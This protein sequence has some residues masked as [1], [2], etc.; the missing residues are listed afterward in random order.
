M[1]GRRARV[2]LLARSHER[3]GT[4]PVLP[5]GASRLRWHGWRRRCLRRE[6]GGGGAPWGFFR[7]P[8]QPPGGGTPAPPPPPRPTPPPP[9]LLPSSG[10]GRLPAPARPTSA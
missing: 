6:A 10:A 2:L 9:P 4:L 1:D 8:P 7:L 5:C 3:A